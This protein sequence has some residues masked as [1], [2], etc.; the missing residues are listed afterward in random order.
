MKYNSFFSEQIKTVRYVPLFLLMVLPALIS[1]QLES[2]RKIQ[3]CNFGVSFFRGT[4]KLFSMKSVH[5]QANVPKPK[6]IVLAGPTGSGKSELAL[7][8]CERI[9]GEIVSADSVQIYKHLQVGANKPSLE[10][11]ERVPHHLVSSVELDANFTAGE[12]CRLAK[13]AMEDIIS[14]G[15]IPVVC[16]GTMMYVQWLVHGVPDAPKSNPD[17]QASAAKMLEPYR[18]K[19]QWEA[20]LELLKERNQSG[21]KNC[22]QM[23]G[24]A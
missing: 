14:R 21:Q 10:E 19:G 5:L 1:Y 9:G 16:G 13:S 17:A 7:R 20:A 6:V 24:T 15:R 22:L 18:E 23:T 8:L 11:L 12:F 4:A 2:R 3:F